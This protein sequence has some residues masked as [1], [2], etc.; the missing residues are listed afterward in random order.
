[1][2]SIGDFLSEER[3]H[4]RLGQLL[5]RARRRA[6]LTQADV[7]SYLRFGPFAGRENISKLENG[8]RPVTWL[9]L[10]AFA[11]L[12]ECA[13]SEFAT[14]SDAESRA[15]QERRDSVDRERAKRKA[16]KE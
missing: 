14:W 16:K 4:H 11:A 2:N 15:L 12:Y 10:E 3:R 9:E 6:K 7:S 8:K 13:V 5:A 1:M